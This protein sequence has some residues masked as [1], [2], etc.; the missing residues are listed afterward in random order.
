MAKRNEYHTNKD[1]GDPVHHIYKKCPA[2]EQI[3]RDGNAIPGTGGFRLCELCAKK[4][5]TGKF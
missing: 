5:R 3:I 1:P 4:D 2:G